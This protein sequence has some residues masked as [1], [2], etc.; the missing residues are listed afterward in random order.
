MYDI[1]ADENTHERNTAPPNWWTW[2][3]MRD[4]PEEKQPRV[5]FRNPTGG[6]R[7]RW[8]RARSR[9]MDRMRRHAKAQEDRP[10]DEREPFLLNEDELAAYLDIAMTCVTGLRRIGRGGEEFDW[11]DGEQ[12]VALTPPGITTEKAARAHILLSFG[13]VPTRVANFLDLC[14]HITAGLREP[15][16]KISPATSTPSSETRTTREPNDKGAGVTSAEVQLTPT[17]PS[18]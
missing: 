12:L 13:P 10:E 2:D 3:A 7:R 17:A 14:N 1:D 4:A 9:M 6:E 16:K 5:V 8:D 18:G 15:Q 11:G